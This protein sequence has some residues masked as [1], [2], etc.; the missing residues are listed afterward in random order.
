MILMVVSGRI[1]RCTLV[2]DMM[3]EQVC[4]AIHL[5]TMQHANAR[6]LRVV[7]IPVCPA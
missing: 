4:T 7:L 5:L 2:Q 3:D 1:N 6:Q